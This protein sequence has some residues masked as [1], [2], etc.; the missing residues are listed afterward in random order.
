[1]LPIRDILCGKVLKDFNNQ[2][3]KMKLRIVK[4]KR[5]TT[6]LLVG[7]LHIGKIR[8]HQSAHICI[9]KKGCGNDLS[10]VV[11]FSGL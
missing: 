10:R 7:P 2:T 11:F 8:D 1:M 6:N 9:R 5:R 4:T 3:M